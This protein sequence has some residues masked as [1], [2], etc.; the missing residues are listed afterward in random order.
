M[1]PLLFHKD[2][3]IPDFAQLPLFEGVLTY[4]RHA[5]NVTLDHADMVRIELPVAFAAAGAT[6]IEAELNASSGALEKQVWRQPLDDKRDLCFAMIAGGFIK[7]CW[8]NDRTDTHDTLQ[9]GR[10]VRSHQWRSMKNK[11]LARA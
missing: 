1:A 7:T 2:I 11:L 9:R 3:F 4:S 10:Y 6:L 5:R 8:V